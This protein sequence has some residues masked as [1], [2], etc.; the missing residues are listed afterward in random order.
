[1]FSVVALLVPVEDADRAFGPAVD[2]VVEDTEALLTHQEELSADLL[3]FLMDAGTKV[4]MRTE[5]DRKADRLT[6]KQTDRQTH[7]QT[8]KQT[9]RE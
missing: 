5:R 1:M 8:D 3:R 4:E 6:E 9:K 2:E 7:S